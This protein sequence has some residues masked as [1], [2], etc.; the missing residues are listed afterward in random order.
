M[1][2]ALATLLGLGLLAS[3]W[4]LG[5]VLGAPR[6][7]AHQHLFLLGLDVK[8]LSPPNKG[9]ALFGGFPF[10]YGCPGLLDVPI[11]RGIIQSGTTKGNSHGR[12]G[13]NRQ[14]RDLLYPEEGTGEAT[15]LWE[16]SRAQPDR[17]RADRHS[18]RDE[19]RR[20]G[21]LRVEVSCRWRVRRQRHGHPTRLAISPISRG[22][23]F[24]PPRSFLFAYL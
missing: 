1:F 21:D 14:E 19:G 10:R 7:A 9:T 20:K 23:S 4:R 2:G 8:L 24:D 22:G 16:A 17:A 6:G 13:L 3:H 5:H 15:H 11:R 12:Y 18:Q